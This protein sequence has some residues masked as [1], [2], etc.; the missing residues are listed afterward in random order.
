MG[1]D[2]FGIYVYKKLLQRTLPKHVRIF[3]A[4]TTGIR[5]LSFFE[6]CDRVYIIDSMNY[7]Q[8]EGTLHRLQF[9]ELSL[10]STLPYSSH[11]V[12]V[13]EL[14]YTIYKTPI[15]NKIPEIIILG[16]EIKKIGVFSEG[17]SYPLKRAVVKTIQVLSSEFN[18]DG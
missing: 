16:A 17:L 7:L 4:G 11:V 2:G 5:S 18:W 14:L 3:D 12:G 8:K 10:S 9:S 15:L 6:N 1:D 13:N